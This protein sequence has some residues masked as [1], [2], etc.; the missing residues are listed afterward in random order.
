MFY[1]LVLKDF[2]VF[3]KQIKEVKKR[4]F[5]IIILRKNI[6]GKYNYNAVLKRFLGPFVLPKNF[7]ENIFIPYPTED[8]K[9]N[10]ILSF[11]KGINTN[12]PI[13]KNQDGKYLNLLLNTINN[14]NNVYIKTNNKNE[15]YKLCEDSMTLY[16]TEPTLLEENNILDNKNLIDIDGFLEKLN[17]PLILSDPLFKDLD[18][19]QLKAAFA[20]N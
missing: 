15:F 17:S 2:K 3:K 11:L 4:G 14:C 16:G 6:F 1:C 13:I 18:P 10:M 9:N 20:E 8:F 5:S 12:K 19:L 7:N